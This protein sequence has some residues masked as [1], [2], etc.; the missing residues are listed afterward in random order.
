MQTVP[1]SCDTAFLYV[2]RQRAGAHDAER[3]QGNYELFHLPTR[4]SVTEPGRQAY[5]VRGNA[6][7][8]VRCARKQQRPPP[9][10]LMF[11]TFSHG[12]RELV[13]PEETLRSHSIGRYVLGR[14]QQLP[15]CMH[16]PRAVRV[17]D[18]GKELRK[19]YMRA[20]S[21]ETTVFCKCT[22][23]HGVNE[24]ARLDRTARQSV[25]RRFCPS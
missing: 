7:S 4:L 20:Y 23:R 1:P 15:S 6:I 5:L 24:R 10:Y 22:P 21:H 2:C 25:P 14:Q 8:A 13:Q 18:V 3:V 9:A 17:P 11:T 12:F 19:G 16:P